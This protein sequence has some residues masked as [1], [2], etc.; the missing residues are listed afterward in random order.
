MRW[1]MYLWKQFRKRRDIASGFVTIQSVKSNWK[2]GSLPNVAPKFQYVFYASLHASVRLLRQ[3]LS[4]STG[5]IMGGRPQ[6]PT[7]ISVV[8]IPKSNL[9]LLNMTPKDLYGQM[10]DTMVWLVWLATHRLIRNE[11]FRIW[12]RR[13][14][15][16]RKVFNSEREGPMALVNVWIIWS[17]PMIYTA[18]LW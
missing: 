3:C 4:I 6:G 9:S 12:G 17:D 16:Y 15:D 14:E 13:S 10:H 5:I 7:H 8:V 11:N 2:V 1:M 18:P